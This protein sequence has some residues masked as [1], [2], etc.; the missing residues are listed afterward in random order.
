MA[1]Q[2]DSDTGN[3]KPRDGDVIAAIK[4]GDF[5]TATSLVESFNADKSLKFTYPNSLTPLYQICKQR[6]Y[7]VYTPLYTAAEYGHL[8]LFQY[9]LDLLFTNIP[10]VPP[11][12]QDETS[13]R[14]QEL[15]L[16][17]GG[18][19]SNDYD[20]PLHVASRRGNL[21]IVKLLTDTLA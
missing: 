20:T 17:I 6:V 2:G 4:S 8:G 21:D 14:K 18:C 10:S 3:S 7:C 15:I 12:S 16:H 11:L 5:K 9:L 19:Y 1:Q 13:R